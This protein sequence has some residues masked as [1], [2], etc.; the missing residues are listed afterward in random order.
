MNSNKLVRFGL[1]F[2][3]AL[4]VFALAQTKVQLQGTDTAV[5][6]NL[7][8]NVVVDSQG[9]L[10]ISAGSTDGGTTSALPTYP[11]PCGTLTDSTVSLTA[12]VV[13]SYG[14]GSARW[15]RVCNSLRNTGNPLVTC[16]VGSTVPTT[17]ATSVGDVL[18]PGDCLYMGNMPTPM[19]CIGDTTGTVLNYTKCLP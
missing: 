2:A 14:D 19:R 16:T 1:V 15:A 6:P 12:G 3:L 5:T 13:N 17:D 9:R 10:I 4:S 8:R 11:A 7:L 18:A